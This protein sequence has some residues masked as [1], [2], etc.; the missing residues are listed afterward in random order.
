VWLTRRRVIGVSEKEYSSNRVT[1]CESGVCVQG[2]RQENRL[3]LSKSSFSLP[4]EVEKS[5]VISHPR[6]FI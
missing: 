2:R 3:K 1:C 5:S 6:Y 4:N